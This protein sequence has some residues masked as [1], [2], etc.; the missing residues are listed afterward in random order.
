MW[1]SPMGNAKPIGRCSKAHFPGNR[2]RWPG[3]VHLWRWS[4]NETS[5]H[6]ALII[7]RGGRLQN[8]RDV[9]FVFEA[10]FFCIAAKTLVFFIIIAFV[11]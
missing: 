7:S 6:Q 3:N 10:P 1:D 8:Y 4:R 9:K 11:G 5:Q 2:L